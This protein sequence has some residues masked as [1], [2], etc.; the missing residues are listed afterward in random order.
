MGFVSVLDVYV[1]VYVYS[2]QLFHSKIGRVRQSIVEDVAYKYTI[3]VVMF[4]SW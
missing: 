3:H 4:V 2:T 1:L